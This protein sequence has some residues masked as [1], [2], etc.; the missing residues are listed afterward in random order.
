MESKTSVIY[1]GSKTLY[2]YVETSCEK[3]AWCK[4]LRLASCDQREK[5]EWFAQL[6]EEFHGY[7]T[8][9]NNEYH[10]FMKPSVGSAVEA[11]E[12]ASKSDGASSKVRHFL[13]KLSKRASRAGVD[14]NKSGWT[15]SS[16]EERKKTEKLRACQDAVLATGLLKTASTANHLKSSMLDD[17]PPLPST[18]SHSG[19]QSHISV[20]SDTDEKFG[21]DEGT[22]CWNLMISRLFFDVKSNAQ[23]KRSIQERIQV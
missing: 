12:R 6:Q 14:N 22:L 2:I 10:S 11:I 3:E 4:A 7:L 5:L 17:A 15:L 8:S 13:R 21:I 18:L 1:H 19:S 23:M 16:R 9:L 20:C